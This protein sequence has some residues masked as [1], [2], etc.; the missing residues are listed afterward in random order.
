[1]KKIRKAEPADLPALLEIFSYARE[2]MKR[3]GNPDQWGDS[4]PPSEEVEAWI[5]DGVQYVITEGEDGESV[6]GTFRFFI[7]EEPAYRNLRGEWVNDEP[8]GVIHSLAS[9]P[10]SHGVFDACV[11][12]CYAQWS[13]L[14]IDT[15]RDNWIMQNLL[16]RAGFERCGWIELED[17]TKRYAYQ[18]CGEMDS[19]TPEENRE[20][21]VLLG[22]NH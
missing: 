14:R 19:V 21:A 16:E 10:G 9:A 11:R 20:P 17:H 6:A 8:Y 3:T 13:N 5:R 1:M 15:H 22:E 7:G 18:R 12:Y 2:K 4:Y